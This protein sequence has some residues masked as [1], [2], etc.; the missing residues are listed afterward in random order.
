MQ[1]RNLKKLCIRFLN[2][3]TAEGVGMVVD[4]LKMLE[5]LDISGCF[6]VNLDQVMS[7]VRGNTNLKM[8]LIEY[9]F[10]QPH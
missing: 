4:N 9:L 5:G 2:L 6:T 3:V 7:K 10:I 8:L 1:M